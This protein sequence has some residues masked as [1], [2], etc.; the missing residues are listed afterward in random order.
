ML[1]RLYRN[2]AVKLND[3]YRVARLKILKK[4]GMAPEEVM[5]ISKV[6]RLAHLDYE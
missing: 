6:S 4:L 2:I 3:F 1:Y 5:F